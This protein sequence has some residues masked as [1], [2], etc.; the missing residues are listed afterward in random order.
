VEEQIKMYSSKFTEFEDV[1]EETRS[2]F[3]TVENRCQDVASRAFAMEA[4]NQKL[5]SKAESRQKELELVLSSKSA[6]DST[7]RQLLIECAE[8]E[9]VCR[10]KQ[11]ERAELTRRLHQLRNPSTIISTENES[12]VSAA[13]ASVAVVSSSPV[14]ASSSSSSSSANRRYRRMDPSSSS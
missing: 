8:A 13:A 9:Q 12:A 14:V 10:K 6:V 5:F 1:G 2:M 7:H 11:V 3:A 4:Q